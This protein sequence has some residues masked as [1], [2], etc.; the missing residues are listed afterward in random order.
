MQKL[1]NNEAWR[2]FT[3]CYK[4]ACIRQRPSNIQQKFNWCFKRLIFYVSNTMQSVFTLS[5]RTS[6]F[7]TVVTRMP[8]AESQALCDVTDYQGVHRVFGALWLALPVSPQNMTWH[9]S[10]NN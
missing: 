10:H 9:L 7:C 2:K 5:H 8:C 1:K 4:E 6:F 3:G